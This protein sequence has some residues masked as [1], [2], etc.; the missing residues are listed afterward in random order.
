MSL[1]RRSR[2]NLRGD[3][4]GATA[5]RPRMG[6]SRGRHRFGS[7][8]V[9]SESDHLRVSSVFDIWFLSPRC[10]I[11][12]GIA[13]VSTKKIDYAC[14]L[15]DAVGREVSSTCVFAQISL[16]EERVKHTVLV[17]GVALATRIAAAVVVASADL[18]I[19]CSGCAPHQRQI[20]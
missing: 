1:D 12:G 7:W 5:H 18:G 3:L 4:S 10:R 14:L 13:L 6:A 2:Q 11:R 15:R 9:F 19:E 8:R 17:T 16:R 20:E